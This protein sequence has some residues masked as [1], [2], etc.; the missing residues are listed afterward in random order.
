MS[1]SNR[2]VLERIVALGGHLMPLKP[3][4]KKALLANWQLAPAITVDE[5]L[6]HLAAGGNVGV[7]LGFSGLI[8]LDAEN[9]PATQHL[10]G[11]GFQLTVAPAKSRIEGNPK[12]QGSHVWLRVP[13]GI[14][15]MTLSSGE[16][17]MQVRLPGG[18]LIDVLAGG[19][20][21]VA[22]PSQLAEAPGWA[23]SAYAGSP[24]D[25]AVPLEDVEVA[26]A[27]KWLFDPTLPC[28]E[29]L[30]ALRG[31]LAPKAR[32]DLAELDARSV[33]LTTEIDQVPWGD[34]I[35][36]DRRLSP[37]G[38]VDGCGCEVWH[39]TDAEHDKSATLH[40]DC[41]VGSGAHLWSGTMMAALR[42]GSHCSRLD[43]ATALRG[44]SRSKTAAS[45]GIR[46]GGEQEL[47]AIDAD[48]LDESAEEA[49]QRGDLTA[50]AELRK[51]AAV[52]RSR[53]HAVAPK[54]GAVFVGADSVVGAPA[55]PA[56]PTLTVVQGGGGVQPAAG[57]SDGTDEDTAIEADDIDA[58]IPPEKLEAWAEIKR[59]G[60][61]PNDRAV[62]PLG[63]HSTPEI[64]ERVM[65]YSDLT[66]ATFHA[67][68]RA[69]AVHPI[70]L[71]LNDLVR[72]GMRLPTDL[73]PFPGQ[74][75]STFVAAVGRSGTG[76]TQSSRMSASPH[77]W[78]QIGRV[79]R[80]GTTPA[81]TGDTPPPGLPE[82][83]IGVGAEAL[84]RTHRLGSG[85]VL[86]DLYGEIEPLYDEDTGKVIKGKSHFLPN[87]HLALHVHEDEMSALIAR[88]GGPQST[89]MQTLCAAW[90][91]A[92]IG[93][94]SRNAGTK[95]ALSGDLDPYNL[96]LTGGLQPARAWTFFLTASLG[97][98]QRFIHAAVTDPYRA[99]GLPVLAD[100]GAVPPPS[101]DVGTATA[102]TLCESIKAAQAEAEKD[103]GVDSLAGFTELD[104]HEL[105]VR[106][107][108]A[109][110]VAAYHGT[111]TVDE[112]CWEHSG[113][114][115]EYSRR[116]R[117]HAEVEKERAAADDAGDAEKLR[118]HGKRVAAADD[119]SRVRSAAN[120]ILGKLAEAG[121]AG[122]TEGEARRWL[123]GV[124]RNGR[125]SERAL[126]GADALRVVK[127][128]EGVT[129]DGIR[130][131]SASRGQ[132]PLT[133]APTIGSLGA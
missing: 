25:L 111:L 77:D 96:F 30:T 122:L 85:Q 14:D 67:A 36:G 72:F 60:F 82:V 63:F 101:L 91:R 1:D 46:L 90:A 129:F 119:E 61:N 107:R 54:E 31:C 102:F 109:C 64:L 20:Y 6:A 37:T 44:E 59:R 35:A 112:L 71:Y 128:S 105:M 70:A 18:G 41:E 88:S 120:R 65:D 94:A 22:P 116:S 92:D 58:G 10:L 24:L 80:P 38:Q 15:P 118:T 33:A 51:A 73:G 132:A 104:S 45:V 108:L 106:I 23:Y 4:I 40:D 5:A 28:P 86:V 27:P 115:M 98:I 52:M 76:K 121:D 87:E 62:Y 53:Q 13:K 34:W 83:F 19:R 81:E 114:I 32:R 110:L 43:L 133:A 49:E 57:E 50:A 56:A 127:A 8:A 131:R 68:R 126:Y 93:D 3:G 130:M 26:E 16:R 95:A 124:R 11:A 74:P 42:L 9:L 123:S 117:A 21:A 100:P 48:D 69:H 103:S 7:H 84:N 29:P 125:P 39:W 99:V 2:A 55:A 97:F 17:T 113:W 79:C 89:T 47:T 66:R 78:T 75:L 12:H